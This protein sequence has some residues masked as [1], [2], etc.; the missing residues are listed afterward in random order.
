MLC[1]RWETPYMQ[2]L[3]RTA[4]SKF[5]NILIH[6]IWGVERPKCKNIATG[7]YSGP[8]GWVVLTQIL[9]KFQFQNLD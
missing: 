5:V 4:A 8:E 2:M 9:I 3:A 1:L 7:T 6:T